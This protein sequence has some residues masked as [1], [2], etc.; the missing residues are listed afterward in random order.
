M[1]LFKMSKPIL[2]IA[3]LAV[4]ALAG[5]AIS[6][7]VVADPWLGTGLGACAGF[8]VGLLIVRNRVEDPVRR[9]IVTLNASAVTCFSTATIAA[10]ASRV[11]MFGLD[12]K[13]SLIVVAMFL[14]AALMCL[15]MACWLASR[16]KDS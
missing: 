6:N 12:P 13:P 9:T 1:I 7:S 16:R 5:A 15:V 4:F 3:T 10:G 11:R 14:G 8:A 2:V